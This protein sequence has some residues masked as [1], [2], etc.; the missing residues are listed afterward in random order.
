MQYTFYLYQTF[1]NIYISIVYC[2]SH[3]HVHK[4]HVQSVV[5]YPSN[6]TRI[7]LGQQINISKYKLINEMK[8]MSMRVNHKYQMRE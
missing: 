4:T 1:K 2:S 8:R 5:S 7:N 3:W 6:L